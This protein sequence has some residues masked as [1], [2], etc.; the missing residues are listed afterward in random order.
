[1]ANVGFTRPDVIEN[2]R[3]I[4]LGSIR[5]FSDG[6][7]TWDFSEAPFDTGVVGS[8]GKF[9]RWRSYFTLKGVKKVVLFQEDSN[10]FLSVFVDEV[11][12]ISS[13]K[14][15]RLGLGDYKRLIMELLK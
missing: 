7:A 5:R 9:L 6:D 2:L 12:V 13:L 11:V 15:G 14:N 3:M 10:G 4:V 8:T 1:M